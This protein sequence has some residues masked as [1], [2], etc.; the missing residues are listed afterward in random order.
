MI[1]INLLPEQLRPKEE[2]KVTIVLRIILIIMP[3]FFVIIFLI[4]LYLGGLLLIKTLQ[5]KTMDKQWMQLEPS[6]Q[7]VIAWLRKYNVGSQGAEV[8]NNLIAQRLTISDKLEKLVEALPNGV[9]FNT[10]TFKGEEFRIQGS[11]VSL[12]KEEVVLLNLF[13]KQLKQDEAFFKDFKNI[14]LGRMSMRMLGGFSIMDFVL[15]GELK[16]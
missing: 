2:D 1:E 10:L 13:L 7:K 16:K 14:E 8:I 9:W 12:K 4:H 11:V 6:R 5:Y 15:E 3:V